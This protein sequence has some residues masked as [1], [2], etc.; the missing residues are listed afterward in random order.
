MFLT[1]LQLIHHSFAEKS[2]ASETLAA[3]RKAETAENILLLG[4][5]WVAEE[6][7][8]IGIYC[9]LHHQWDFKSGVLE[10]IN[11]SGDS[12]STGCIAG[13]ILGV[14]NGENSIPEKWRKNLR[15]YRI[16]SQI[17]D[18]LHCHFE[19]NSEGQVTAEWWNK[20]P[21]Y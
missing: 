7:L 18:D 13:H 16:V 21:G 9:A 10:A 3:I 8:A 6:A 17:A 11:I 2:E 4:E 14:L 20:Y 15:E 1:Y 12:D 5:G 19:K